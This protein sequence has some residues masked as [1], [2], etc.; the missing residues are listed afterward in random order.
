MPGMSG[1]EVADRLSLLHPEMKVLF[2]TG[3]A[4]SAIVHHGILE[5]GIALLLK[6]FTPDAL[7]Q[8]VRE[9][10]DPPLKTNGQNKAFNPLFESNKE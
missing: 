5:P 6:P 10:L 1:R 3:Y 7:A 9:V 8:K 2:M 4:D